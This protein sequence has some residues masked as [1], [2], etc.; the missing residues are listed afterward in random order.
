MSMKGIV[1]KIDFAIHMFMRSK[2]N[3]KVPLPDGHVLRADAFTPLGK[4]PWPV[5]LTTFPYQKDGVGG[6]LSLLEGY[7]L[8]KAG[9]AVVMAD[10]R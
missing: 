8:V 2:K 9:Y 1:K 3:L 4:G 10:L 7:D 6:G 5:I